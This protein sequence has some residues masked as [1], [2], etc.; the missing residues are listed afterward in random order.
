LLAYSTTVY[1]WIKLVHVLAA[2]TWV[3]SSIFV[4]LYATKLDRAGDRVRLA[5][6]AQDIEFF[7]GRLFA[8]AS[9]VVLLVGLVLVGYDPR[10]AV[11]DLWVILAILGFLYTFVTGAFVLGPESGKLG[12]LI[13]EGRSPDDPELQRRIHKVF[14]VSR[15]DL[16]VLVLVVVDMVVKP[17]S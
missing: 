7:G 15:F 1:D 8:P 13:E 9:V 6:F 2:I 17:G 5:G 10:W 11:K 3:G 12:R 14:L 4:Q 16:L